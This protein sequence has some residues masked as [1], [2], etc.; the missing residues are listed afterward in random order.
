MKNNGSS[1]IIFVLKRNNRLFLLISFLFL[2]GFASF[3]QNP[4]RI[5]ILNANSIEFDRKIRRDVKRLLGDVQFKQ[6]NALM[7]C[8]SAYLNTETNS[9]E[10]FSNVHIKQGD[11]LN[12]YGDYL[13]YDGNIKLAQMRR[14]VKMLHG[15]AVLTTEFLDFNRL[16]DVAYYYNGGTIIDSINHLTSDR[17][18]YYVA[19]KD[20]Y[21]V[22]SVSLI[23]PDYTMNTDSLRYNISSNIS[24]FYGPTTIISDSNFIYCE[25]GWYDTQK[26]LSQYNKN[27]YLKTKEKKLS[28]DSLFYDRNLAYGEA[29]RNVTLIDTAARWILSGDY[30][31]YYQNKDRALATQKALMTKIDGTDSLFL[32]ADT[33]I[34]YPIYLVDTIQD[35]LQSIDSNYINTVDTVK[36]ILAYHKVQLYK[37]DFQA[38]CDSLVYSTKDS[39]INLFSSPILWAD[40]GQ[41]IAD[42]M[43]LLMTNNKPHK[44]ILK[45][46]AFAMMKYD[47]A[48][49]HQMKGEIINAYFTKE[50][51]LKKIDVFGNSET[52]Y[53]PTEETD[54][55]TIKGDVIG[56]NI[57][58]SKHLTIFFEQKK[59]NKIT[60]YDN[61]E[62]VLNPL[63]KVKKDKMKLKGFRNL[64]YLRPL[65]KQDIFIW[66]EKTTIN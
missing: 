4:K 44:A 42:S 48:Y 31:V 33:L 60:M 2:F 1:N 61:P 26:N 53:F 41:L 47:T 23:N 15:S 34:T 51:Q 35:T 58:K 19:S 25:N 52:I 55:D 37:K 13:N 16:K 21:A 64:Y 27:A 3:S 59:L 8:D 5:E 49:Y 11:S 62:G 6:G 63:N 17:G 50:T 65:S 43:K 18:Y 24:Y 29:F 14:N 10:A 66:K 45:D 12:L 36:I 39:T 54:N 57:T 32:H 22:D 28:G 38:R 56:V 40:D 20:Y 30:A 9:F 7:F 46:R